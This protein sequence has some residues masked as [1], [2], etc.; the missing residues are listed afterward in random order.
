MI[1]DIAPRWREVQRRVRESAAAAGRDPD[2]IRIVAVSKLQPPEKVAAAVRCGVVEIG[3]NRVQEAARKRP[4]IEKLLEAG[5]FDAARVRWHMVGHLQSN[6]AARAARLFDVVQSVDT[7]K[8]ATLLSRAAGETGRGLEVFVEVNTS[9]E[10]SKAGIRPDEVGAFVDDIAT[11]P[12]LKVVGF[13]TVG[14]LTEDPE[15]IIHAFRLLRTI[16]DEVRSTRSQHP[17]GGELSMGMSGDF[18]PAIAEGATVV[19][20]GTAIFGPRPDAENGWLPT[21]R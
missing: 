10:A 16:R 6:K 18:E 21:A 1:D 2:G 17:I 3:E 7:V 19:R 12:N 8:V 9:G 20:I 13:M 11:L 4:L 5:G 15:R 14:P